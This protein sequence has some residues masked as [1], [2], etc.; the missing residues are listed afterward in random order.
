LAATLSVSDD[1]T[2][3]FATR[4]SHLTVTAV[5]RVDRPI[6]GVIAAVETEV[7]GFGTLLEFTDGN[8]TAEF[9]LPAGSYHITARLITTFQLTPIDMSV[10]DDVTLTDA[11]V[12]LTL[13]LTEYEPP[14]YAT[15]AF[16]FGLLVAI[17]VAAFIA[18]VYLR[19]HR[20]KKKET[21]SETKE[22]ETKPQSPPPG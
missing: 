1:G 18:F 10:E 19:Y 22:T 6:P 12:P 3:T 2:S 8:G 4:V 21:P 15:N 5:D 20:R 14:I 9:R 11:D 7:P 16:L 17:L 13:R